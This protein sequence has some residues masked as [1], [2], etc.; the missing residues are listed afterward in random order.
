MFGSINDSEEKRR[1]DEVAEDLDQIVITKTKGE[2]APHP[3]LPSSGK[4]MYMAYLHKPET[5]YDSNEK[6]LIPALQT[7]SH[8][9]DAE[10]SQEYSYDKA[11]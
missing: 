3:S 1:N 2:E 6:K 10:S 4:D 11:G 8:E 9:A 5:E 7:I